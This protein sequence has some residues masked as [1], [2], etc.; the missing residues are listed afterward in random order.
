MA[1]N[2]EKAM[3]K[4]TD[5]WRSLNYPFGSEMPWD[6]TG[7]EE[8]Y[9]WTSYFGYDDK[10]DVTLNAILA[11]MPTV[12]HWGYNGSARRYWDFMFGGKLDR[13]ERQLHHYG[14]AL[15]A[16]PALEAY[17][18]NPNDFHLLRIGHAGTM[19]AL[20]N[21]T[22]DGFGPAAFHS[23]PSTLEID[24]Y[25]GDY[26][27]G[28]YGYAVNSGTYIINHPEFGWNAFSGNLRKENNWIKTEI[29]SA[30][31]NRVFIAPAHV[32]LT[33][34]AGKMKQ[35]DYNPKT[36]EI[37]VH[38]EGDTVV[39]GIEVPEGKNIRIPAE[40]A[41]DERG[42]YIFKPK[43]KTGTLNLIIQ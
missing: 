18:K 36:E 15:N 2:L 42:Y 8:V 29:T 20:A 14:S 19:G 37:S 31:Q 27:C 35:V 33:T 9:M 30:G 11:Y 4:R 23:F 41:K 40:V 12:P 34:V 32:F 24:G 43:K 16:I 22:Q 7:Q 26:G 17:R 21:I 28:F 39:L 10:A 3:K 5:H 13:T 38:V 1:N 25:A 6:S